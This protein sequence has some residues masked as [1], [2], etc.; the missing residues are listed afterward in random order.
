[1]EG[2][3]IDTFA[4]APVMAYEYDREKM[5]E[6]YDYI[7][8]ID[9]SNEND[10]N[11]KSVSKYILNDEPLSDL[12]TF[13]QE[14]ITNYT[15]EICGIDH[16]IDMQQSWVNVNE[17]GMEHPA[18]F[19]SNSFLSGVFY[20]ASEPND[21]SPIKFH[22]NLRNFHYILDNDLDHVEPN[23]EFNPYMCS[24]CDLVSIPGN[25]LIFSSK[26]SHSVPVNKS[27][28]NRISISFNSFPKIPFGGHDRLN[29][30]KYVD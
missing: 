20:V 23:E 12:K 28:K 19:H 16:Q 7:K 1:M 15:K 18:H 17:P 24:S 3:K 30:I 22:S 29:L 11:F 21:G 27:K 6:V 10:C 4:L 2:T 26:L 25:L 13:C 5:Q 8:D 9:Y 14:A